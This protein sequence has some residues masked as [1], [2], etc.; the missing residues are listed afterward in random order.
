MSEQK[1]VQRMSKKYLHPEM[2]L[3]YWIDLKMRHGKT[4]EQAIKEI[5]EE[6]P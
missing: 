6:N 2:A 1:L 5:E 4:R 3:K